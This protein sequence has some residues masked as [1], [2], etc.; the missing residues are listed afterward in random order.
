MKPHNLKTYMLCRHDILVLDE[1]RT[2]IWKT[3][4]YKS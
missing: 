3:Q 4:R 1:I 2:L